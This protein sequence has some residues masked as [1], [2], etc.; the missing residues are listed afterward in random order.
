ME[1]SDAEG[2]TIYAYDVLNQLTEVV[3]PDGTWQRNTYDASGIRSMVVENGV[4]TEFMSFNGLVLSGYDKDGEQTEHYY[5]GTGL[6]A[7]ELKNNEA[8]ADETSLYY[9]LRNSHGDVVGLTDNTGTLTETY[10][11]NAFGALTGIQSLN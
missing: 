7:A 1:K 11:Y 10:H 5:Y 3:N 2:T 6:L 8:Y 4:T 9:Y